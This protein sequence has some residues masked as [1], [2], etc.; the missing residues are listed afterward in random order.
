MKANQLIWDSFRKNY[1]KV[2]K[3]VDGIVYL[4][5]YHYVRGIKCWFYDTLTTEQFEKRFNIKNIN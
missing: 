5:H 2:R 3:V 4:T 1:S